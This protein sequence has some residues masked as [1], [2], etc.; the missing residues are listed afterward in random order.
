[1]RQRINELEGAITQIVQRI[2]DLGLDTAGILKDI[3]LPLQLQPA[4]KSDTDTGTSSIPGAT[5]SFANLALSDDL[6]ANL[7]NTPFLALLNNDVISSEK[8]SFTPGVHSQIPSGNLFG[9]D[10]KYGRILRDLR[11]LTPSPEAITLIIR[12]SQLSICQLGKSFLMIHKVMPGGFD[13]SQVEA[14]RD[15]MLDAFKSDDIAVITQVLISLASC[16]QQLPDS[17]QFGLPDSLDLLQ[18]RYMEIAEEALAPDEGIVGSVDGLDC[19]LTQARYYLHGGLPRKAW[20]IFRRAATFAQL[21]GSLRQDPSEHQLNIRKQSLWL[22][23]WQMDKNISLLLGLPYI[24][25][26]LPFKVESNVDS[27]SVLPPKAVFIFKLGEIS[28]RIIDRN[29]QSQIDTSYSVTLEIDRDFQRCKTVMPSSWW[30]KLPGPD[31]SLDAIYEMCIL[32]FMSHNLRNYI[33]LPFV[34]KTSTDPKHQFSI[35]TAL[36]SSRAMIRIYEMLRDLNRPIIK[37]CNML[38]FQVLTAALT[39][40]LQLLGNPLSYAFQQQEQDWE[41]IYGLI[42]VMK[43]ATRDMPD[44]LA[45]QAPQLLEDLSKLRYDF[46]GS[47]QSFHA[48]VPYF[49]EIRIRRRDGGLGSQP[50]QPSQA[51]QPYVS[52]PFPSRLD[53]IPQTPF[54][55]DESIGSADAQ[56]P[57]FDF[58]NFDFGLENS[59]VWPG[60]DQEWAS[61]VDYTLQDGWDWDL[62]DW[63]GLQ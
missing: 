18:R 44:T 2:D 56:M 26:A 14:L 62:N 8:I 35:F 49:G 32:K 37:V 27:P 10:A 43:H 30:D 52:S 31:M 45:A 17:D 58:N 42:H 12:H 23:I 60:P 54:Q 36:E 22:Q 16:I 50:P 9:L 24:L 7:E 25:S 59:Q 28:A 38:D 13:D 47:H 1:M 41:I 63:E 53:L 11:P 39:I 15:Y 19:L 48:V 57:L 6:S 5:S 29:S 55:V 46:S 33:H 3:D 51:S 40:I 4:S 21:L 20:V 61:M 34:L